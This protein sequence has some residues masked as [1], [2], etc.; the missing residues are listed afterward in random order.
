[1]PFNYNLTDGK[2]GESQITEW[3][4]RKGN[5]CLPVYEIADGQFKGPT[6]YMADNT[7]LIAP[8]ILVFGKQRIFFVEAKHKEAFTMH[9][10]T[11]RW[12]TGIDLHHY[13][14][15]QLVQKT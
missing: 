4:R 8:D 5:H 13:E 9:R 11:N 7:Q 14:Q 3:L 6:L 1:M 15:Y 2:L 12:V 10:K